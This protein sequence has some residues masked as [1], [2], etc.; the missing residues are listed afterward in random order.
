MNDFIECVSFPK[1][2]ISKEGIVRNKKTKCEIKL[3]LVGEYLGCMLYRD[4][5]VGERIH[6]HR[7]LGLTFIPNPDNKPVI[8]HID[9]NKL[10][11]NIENLRWATLSENRLN[12]DN[13][14][15]E[16]YWRKYK[17]E[18]A[19]EYR[20]KISAEE[21]EKKLEKRREQYDNEKQREYINRPDVKEKRLEDQRRKRNIV[22]LFNQLP[23]SF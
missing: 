16:E 2:E 22:K 15:N 12:S 8:D 14:R 1:Y 7:L 17:T 4:K 13:I 20:A 5:K 21:K 6:L 9:R 18:K 23:F 19:R 10:N 11:N 3:Y